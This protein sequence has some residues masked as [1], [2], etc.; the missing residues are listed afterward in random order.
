MVL[1][2]IDFAI[3]TGIFIVFLGILFGYL[4]SYLLNYRSIAE[5]S[6]LRGIA[7]D[8]FTTFFIDKGV[9][10][11]WEDS[12]I[13]PVKIGLMNNLYRIL[14]NVTEK[15][16]TQRNNIAINGSVEFDL[17]CNRKISNNTIRL[18]NSNNSEV[19][20]QLYNQTFCDGGYLKTGEIVFNIS[21]QPYQSQFFFLYFSSEK[22]VIPPNYSL[23]FP[24]NET[25]YSFEI[26]PVQELQMISVNKLIA[27]RS[28]NYEEV[29]QTIPKGYAFRV[30]LS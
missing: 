21:L 17:S 23:P 4:V 12:E 13:A 3:A 24:V 28:L 30:E 22:N 1:S 14:I 19:P 29:L 18:Y 7:S 2:H 5:S 10:A 9:P 11:N 20:F 8:L 15:N 27:L 26:F 6:D 16:G 25:N